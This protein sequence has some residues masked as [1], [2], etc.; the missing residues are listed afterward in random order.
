VSAPAGVVVAIHLF[1]AKAQ[2][3]RSV[4]E[5]RA[6]PGKGL[7][8]DRYAERRGS[9]S[10]RGGPQREVTL[11]EEEAIEALA[12]D[13]RV[14][15]APGESRRNIT[16]RGV[17]LNHLVGREFRVGE[18]TLRGVKLCEPCSHLEKLTKPG[19]LKG[20]IHRGGLNAQVVTGGVLR[21]GDPVL[22]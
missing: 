11:I 4:A 10:D 17:A 13:Y 20:L 1:P 12:R 22:P 7:E 3:G 5:C 6:V 8:G 21:V 2:E 9:F 19:V 14:E 15:L 16:T 18:V